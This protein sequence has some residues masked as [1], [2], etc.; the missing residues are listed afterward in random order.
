MLSASR[1]S[2]VSQGFHLRARPTSLL[3]P[4]I[5]GL[6][7]LPACGGNDTSSNS[8]PTTPTGTI[9][10]MLASGQ[11]QN[12]TVTA[13]QTATFTATGTAPL[14]YQWEKDSAVL[15][16]ATGAFYTK[17]ATTLAGDGS[18]FTVT[19]SNAGGHVTS[20]AA[21]LTVHPV[22]ATP[23]VPTN[24]S[25]APD[26]ATQITL[27]WMASIDDVAVTGYRIYRNGDEAGN[28][29]GTQSTDSGLTASTTEAR[30][31]DE[32]IVENCLFEYTTGQAFQYYCGGIDIYHGRRWIVRNNLFQ[33]IRMPGELTEG[34]VHFWNQSSDTL[35]EGNKILNCDRGIL[36]GMDTSPHTGGIIRNNMIHVVPDTGIYLCNAA[37][38]RVVHN[39]I[40]CTSY[41]NAIEYRFATTSGVLIANNL[42]NAGVRSRDGA[43]GT[44]STN[45]AAAAADWFMNL[46]QGDLH[47]SRAIPEVVNQGDTAYAVTTDF[48]GRPRE[49]VPDIGAGEY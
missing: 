6:M 4:A 31:S 21:T 33:D 18:S 3:L 48:D 12:Q 10:A 43:T 14:G 9:P 44:E 16:G 19:V 23:S 22:S 5:V 32:G 34:A 25:G 49:G 20:S 35:V 38:A 26:S 11:P 42:S 24:L 17:P 15:D 36:F 13:G 8:Q 1:I 28:I 29:S 47:L 7:L 40:W 37:G 30:F 45:L 2:L 46:N 39:T 41:P 27:A